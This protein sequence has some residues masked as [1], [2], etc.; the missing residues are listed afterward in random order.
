MKAKKYL[1]AMVLFG[2]MVFTIQTSQIIDLNEQPTT[3]IEKSK[4]RVPKHG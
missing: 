2:G 1:I 4:I 3:E